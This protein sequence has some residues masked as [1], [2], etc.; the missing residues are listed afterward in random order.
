[1]EN[2]V[3]FIGF[4]DVCSYFQDENIVDIIY[5]GAELQVDD[6]LQRVVYVE[7]GFG[8]SHRTA[9]ANMKDQL[10]KLLRA[11]LQTSD[12][13]GGGRF[14]ADSFVKKIND[15]RASHDF[16]AGPRWILDELREYLRQQEFWRQWKVEF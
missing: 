8:G 12:V 14:I 1:M 16:G 15:R 5:L 4:E 6:Q 2:E 10:R 11:E 7:L 3:T 13:R 9:F